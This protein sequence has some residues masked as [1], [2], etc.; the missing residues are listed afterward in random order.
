MYLAVDYPQAYP[1][2]GSREFTSVEVPSD[3][4]RARHQRVV[5]V[6]AADLVRVCAVR[7]C[8]GCSD[9]RHHASHASMRLGRAGLLSL[10]HRDSAMKRWDDRGLSA[11]LTG[12]TGWVDFW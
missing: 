2:A 8:K 1:G 6:G 10:C 11:S 3:K 12:S 9:I 4:A 5:D 7:R